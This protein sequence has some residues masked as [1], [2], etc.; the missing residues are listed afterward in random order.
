M[1][2]VVDSLDDIYALQ[3]PLV[4][5][6]VLRDILRDDRLHMLLQVRGREFNQGM[7]WGW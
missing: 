3:D 7:V 5:T 4:E 2:K 1:Q 6:D